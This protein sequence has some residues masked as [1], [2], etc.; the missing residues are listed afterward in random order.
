MALISYPDIAFFIIFYRHEY[1]PWRMQ[2]EF[3]GKKIRRSA[4]L[5]QH[6]YLCKRQKWQKTL[7][8][9]SQINDTHLTTFFIRRIILGESKAAD[10]M[11]LFLLNYLFIHR[12]A[13]FGKFLHFPGIS[14]GAE[15]KMP[16]LFTPQRLRRKFFIFRG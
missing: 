9:H 4:S 10:K 5:Q 8:Q 13:S 15:I 3:P 14:S 1:K 6:K 16:N 12:F 11:L 2:R 7:L